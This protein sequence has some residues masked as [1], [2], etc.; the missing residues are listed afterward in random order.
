MKIASIMPPV[1]Q[2][3]PVSGHRYQGWKPC[4]EWC[5]KYC[6]GPWLFVSEGV[7]EFEWDTDYTLFML[8][9]A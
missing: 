4:I 9:W 6:E 7:F 2:A 5:D 8:R 3:D 1:M